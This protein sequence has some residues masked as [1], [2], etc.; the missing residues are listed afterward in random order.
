MKRMQRSAS[1]AMAATLAGS[2]I[3]F[4]VT[5]GFNVNYGSGGTNGAFSWYNRSGGVKGQVWD[6]AGGSASTT[7]IF[8]PYAGSYRLPEQSRAAANGATTSFN[9]T[10]DGSAYSGG[11]HVDWHRNVQQYRVHHARRGL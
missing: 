11:D 5:S 8:A 7:A 10:L 4:A 6:F 2:S 9:F 3:A 1:L